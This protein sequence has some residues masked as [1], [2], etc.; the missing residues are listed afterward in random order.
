[1]MSKGDNMSTYEPQYNPGVNY[2]ILEQ[3]TYEDSG[4]AV[5]YKC[6]VC[7]GEYLPTFIT[8]EDGQIMC[9]DCWSKKYNK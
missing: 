4:D 9:I 8:E 1:M 3:N 7:G 6:P 2:D 5:F